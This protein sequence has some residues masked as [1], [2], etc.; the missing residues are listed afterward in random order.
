MFQNNLEYHQVQQLRKRIIGRIDELLTA[1]GDVIK[2][3]RLKFN[4][5]T[6]KTIK[7]F[8]AF[9]KEVGLSKSQVDA[10]LSDLL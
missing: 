7:E 1:G 9:A 3:G 4:G 6:D 5:F 10:M 8:N 2:N